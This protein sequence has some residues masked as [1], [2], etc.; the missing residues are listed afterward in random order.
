MYAERAAKILADARA[1]QNMP[2]S[3]GMSDHARGELA[4]AKLDAAKDIETFEPILYPP[5]EPV[6]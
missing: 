2:F 3:A 4:R 5:D 6:N 1:I